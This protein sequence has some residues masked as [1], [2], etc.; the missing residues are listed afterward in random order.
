M[1]ITRHPTK[2]LYLETDDTPQGIPPLFD[3]LFS[4][5]PD[6][7]SRKCFGASTGP[8]GTYRACIERMD[9]DDAHALGMQEWELPGGLFAAEQVEDWPDDTGKI[10]QA[11]QRLLCKYEDRI[12]DWGWG[13]EDYL[14][15]NVVNVLIKINP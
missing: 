5:I 8:A 7:Q 11:F 15:E 10:A 3:Q 1:E 14:T 6:P 9:G 13:L 4:L 12:S 2:V